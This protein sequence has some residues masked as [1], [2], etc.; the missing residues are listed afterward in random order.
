MDAADDESYNM[1]QHFDRA[2]QFID[3]AKFGEGRCL[4]HC[5]MGIN[6]SG[7]ICAAYIIADQRMKLLDAVR[8]MKQRRGT[9]LC[10]RGFQRL[11][12]RFARQRGLL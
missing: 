6:R 2:S 5:A 3:R 10:N 7:A 11:L 8:L 4:V 9:V 1:L 12:I